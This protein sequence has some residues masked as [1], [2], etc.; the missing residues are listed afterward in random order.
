MNADWS[1]ADRLVNGFY[2]PAVLWVEHP[3]LT[4][5]PVTI[6]GAG[7]LHLRRTRHRSRGPLIATVLWVMYAAYEGIMSLWA[8][9]VIAPIRIDLIV[10]GPVMYIVTAMGLVS[11]WRARRAGST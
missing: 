3:A 11:W 1:I 8:Q 5:V 2:W 9:H 7:F 4:L 10:L 6:F